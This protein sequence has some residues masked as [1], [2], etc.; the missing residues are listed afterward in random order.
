MGWLEAGIKKDQE[1]LQSLFFEKVAFKFHDLGKTYS[2]H[3]V[4]SINDEPL[5]EGQKAVI[6]FYRD[7]IYIPF[8]NRDPDYKGTLIAYDYAGQAYTAKYFYRNN[9][10]KSQFK[11][12]SIQQFLKELYTNAKRNG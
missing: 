4:V 12:L 10:K 5:K 2:K 3:L 11:K 8:D 6:Y 1:E 9:L 7:D